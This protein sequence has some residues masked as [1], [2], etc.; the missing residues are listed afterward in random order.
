[1][2]VIDTIERISKTILPNENLKFCF[3]TSDKKP[4][5]ID[6]AIARPNCESDFVSFEDLFQCTNIDSYAGLGISIQAS[7]ICAID[8]DHCFSI[9]NDI[10]SADERA[11]K[12]LETFKDA[13]CEFSFSGTGLR[14]LFRSALIDHYSDTY[15]VKNERVQIEY[16][17]PS[18]SFRYVTVTGN[19]ITDGIIKEIESDRLYS[20]LDEFMKKPE[21][22]KYSASTTSD[23][24]RSFEQLQNLVKYHYFK[25]NLFQNL[26]FGQAPG[27]GK[28]ESERDYAI[29]VFLF[30]NVTQDKTLLK[31]L[32]ESSPFFKS[33]DYHH[34]HKWTN[35][36]FRYYNYIYDQIRRTH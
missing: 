29:I 28:D 3:V 26:W 22:K 5:K 31:Q 4:V 12:I 33:K 21:R 16:Y 14:V 34:Q 23:E 36:D 19:K 8:V 25:N 17:Q 27:S 11:K 1:M 7:K 9:A 35:Q 2:N 30:E 10:E 6:G 13:Y 15:Y 20:F 18:H 24:T 32:F